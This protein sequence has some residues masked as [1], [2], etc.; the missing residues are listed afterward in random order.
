MGDVSAMM[1]EED[2]ELLNMFY[3]DDYKNHTCKPTHSTPTQSITHGRHTILHIE[4][5]HTHRHTEL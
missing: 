3:M 5:H 4:L 1:D 2:Y